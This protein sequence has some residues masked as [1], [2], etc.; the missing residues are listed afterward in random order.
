MMPLPRGLSPAGFFRQ[1]SRRN[2]RI[3]CLDTESICGTDEASSP[4]GIRSVYYSGNTKDGDCGEGTLNSPSIKSLNSP[5]FRNSPSS[6][7]TSAKKRGM[8]VIPFAPET[9]GRSSAHYLTSMNGCIV[10]L[11]TVEAHLTMTD[12]AVQ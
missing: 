10:K 3:G 4:G 7:F 2:S 12:T 5:N 8:K 1:S 9:V 6:S 11:N